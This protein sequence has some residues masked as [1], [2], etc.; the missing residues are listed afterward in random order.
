MFQADYIDGPVIDQTGL[1]GHYGMKLTWTP[2]RLI[3]T[4]GGLTV[5][6]ALIRQLGLRL[7]QRK[8][9]AAVIVIDRAEGLAEN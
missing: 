5:F 9:S 4:N 7:E 6:D 8:V 1:T 2:Q 3:E